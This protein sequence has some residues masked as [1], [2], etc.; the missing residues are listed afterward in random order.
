MQKISKNP[1]N[2]TKSTSIRALDPEFVPTGRVMGGIAKPIFS[3]NYG[4]NID[5]LYQTVSKSPEVL[6]C[7][8]ALVK[9]IMSDGWRFSSITKS[10][11]SKNAINKAIMFQEKSR[12]Y[13]VLTNA[14]LDLFITGN[15]YILK[16]SVSED[17]IKSLIEKLTTK[18][19]KDL[20]IKI[21]KDVVYELV[22][23]EISTDNIKDLQLIKSSTVIIN[24]DETGHVI[25]YE[26]RVN[27]KSRVFKEK[28]V[29]HL[30]L[31]NIGGEPYGFTPLET[32][33]S[34]IAT[35]IYAKEYAG[36][37][38]EN[39]GI[40]TFMFLMKKEHPNSPNYEKLKSEL[41]ELKKS[42]NKWKSL[43]LT[44][45]VDYKEIQK[46]NK[47][48]EFSKLIM[49]F[50]QIILMAYGVPAHRVNLTIDVRQI[51]GA[52][53]RAYEGYYKD[54]NFDQ[55]CIQETLN[56]D[57]WG[58]FGVRMSFKETYKIDEMR[59]A[60]IVQILTQISSIT[61]EEAREMMG[62]D[63]EKPKGTEPTKTS[64]TF[65]NTA[66]DINQ[67][68]QA[69]DPNK[70]QETMDNKLKNKSISD[71]L[72]VSWPD[73][74]K[75][76]ESKIGQGKFQ[77]ANVLYI[78]T[79]SDFLLFFNDGNWKYQTRIE[80]IKLSEIGYKSPEQFKMERLTYAVNIL[81]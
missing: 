57:L 37:Y 54:I 6:A 41:K 40:P 49:H 45:E 68:Q 15:A 79:V 18:M 63:P 19:A 55:Q 42:T 62:L 27:G 9:D 25:S 71:G 77:N 12:F 20:N 56:R 22:N 17:T 64:P 3:D 10:G 50:T 59:E 70:P 46:F 21:K 35:L 65:G 31:M 51:G 69:Q 58:F 1:R 33:L 78:E 81:M 29:I 2:I 48:L 74:V 60:Q 38:F 36:K 53:N 80:K 8:S 14:L 28:D 72:L 11:K 76:V 7:I 30:T 75:I 13:Q 47:D 66:T 61:I 32:L 24:F 39:D 23:Q 52:V 5:T 43:C 73:F 4:A 44:G 16:L 67:P 26:Q 34:D